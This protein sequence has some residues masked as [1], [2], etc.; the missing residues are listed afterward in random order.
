MNHNEERVSG[1]NVKDYLERP[2]FTSLDE[3]RQYNKQRLAGAFRLFSRFGF[4]EGVAGHATYRDPEYTDHMW[5]NPYG[6]A[7]GKIKASD[8]VLVNPDGEVVQGKY[9]LH[10]SALMI[11]S[12]IHEA[13]PDVIS[14]VHLHSLYGKTW[15]STGRLIDPLTQDACA[16]YNDHSVLDEFSGVVY[17]EDEG[18]KVAKAL[19]DNKAM[20]L[21]NHGPLTVGQSVDSAAFWFITLE[22]SCQVQ[23]L[24]EAAGIVNPIPDEF[25]ASTAK[26]VGREADGWEN[27]QPLW[28]K[29]VSEEPDFL[30]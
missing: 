18:V 29:I 5:V 1:E 27:F 7:F 4:T 13:R 2:T 10:K 28:E 24:A 30:D 26:Q 16:F 23:L 25:A 12:A 3:E 9:S 17:E 22:R 20:F 19:A 8:L 14:S 6:I 11:H 21:K 15:A